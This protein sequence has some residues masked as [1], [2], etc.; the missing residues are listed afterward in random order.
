MTQCYLLQCFPI[1]FPSRGA[2][3]AVQWLGELTAVPKVP[4]EAWMLNCPSLAPPEA[5]RLCAKN[6]S[7]EGAR[8]NPRSHL[9]I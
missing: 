3:Q 1:H 9:S 7:M 8:F 4:G 2:D 6:W 5:A